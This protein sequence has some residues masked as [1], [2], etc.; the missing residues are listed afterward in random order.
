MTDTDS[1]D[2]PQEFLPPTLMEALAAG[3]VPDK[4][5]KPREL[6]D[7]VTL[8]EAAALYT[9]VRHL[10][11]HH[12]IEIGLACGISSLAILQAI[13]D[14]GAG[15]HHI[16][17][18]YQDQLYKD[19][20]LELIRKAGLDGPMKF[21]PA[22]LEQVFEDI[23]HCQFAFVDNGHLFDRTISIFSMIDY[24]LELDGIIGF[25]D[26]Y[27]PSQEKVLRCILANRPYSPCTPNGK[28][29]TV[30]P[31]FWSRSSLVKKFLHPHL[32]TPW[33]SFQL[34]DLAML[35][36]QAHDDRNWDFHQDF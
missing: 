9:A 15:T 4:L 31:P 30:S 24:K 26:T 7:N 22:R 11:P 19:A 29:K 3:S 2:N 13:H 34:P 10:R 28:L 27:L 25:H 8:K 23:P 17:D 36:K 14:N 16:F 1:M 32:V 33:R 20:G 5:G 35:L 12:S 21:Y 6:R 18:P